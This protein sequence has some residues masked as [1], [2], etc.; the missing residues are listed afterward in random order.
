M[1]YILSNDN[2]FYVALEQSYGVA[3]TISASNR[4][5]AVK[6]T[7][8]QQK[9]KVQRADK[10]GS[11]TFAG[12]PSGLRI[13]TSFGLK[14]YMANWADPSSACRPMGRCFRRAWVATAGA[15]GGGNVASAS[16][17]STLA[18]TSPHGL[19]A[20][21]GSNQRRRNSLRDGGGECRHRSTQC[22]IFGYS[23]YELA[24]RPDGHVSDGRKSFRA[25]RCTITGALRRRCSAYLG[26]WRWTRYRSKSTAISMS[27]ISAGRRRT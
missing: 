27:L 9:E 23:D 16:G 4:I 24:N 8:K 26:A 21:R 13:Q 18:F 25:L 7:T 6:L 19:A 12:N 5:P 3:A 22:P 2:R 1:S 15:I 20:G 10:T 17:S 14:T 11:R